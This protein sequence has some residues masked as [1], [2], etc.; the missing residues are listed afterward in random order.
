MATEN[1][2][3][4]DVVLGNVWYGSK[5]TWLA[6]PS[7]TMLVSGAWSGT[8]GLPPLGFGVTCVTD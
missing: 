4:D 3:S 8:G 6:L 5:D 2:F 1:P 7:P